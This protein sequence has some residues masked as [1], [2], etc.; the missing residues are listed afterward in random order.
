MSIL[1]FYRVFC[2]Q[3]EI[4]DLYLSLFFTGGLQTNVVH[5]WYLS[6]L[7]Y[8]RSATRCC[9]RFTSIMIL[10]QEVCNQIWSMIYVYSC[11]VTG[12]N[13]PG[14]SQ[15]LWQYLLCY[16][17]YST[18]YGPYMSSLAFVP[19]VQQ[20]VVHALWLPL[21]YYKRYST[22]FSPYMSILAFVPGGVQPGMVHTFWLTLF[23]Y[24]RYSTKFSP[25][26]FILVFVSG[27]VQPGMVH[28][29]WLPLPQVLW[30]SQR[31][32]RG[33]CTAGLVS[34]CTEPSPCTGVWL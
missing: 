6:L 2:N 16:R 13:K 27:G 10:L 31:L 21:F 1:A 12:G 34:I 25:Y 17:R 32:H 33:M 4:Y 3:N 15:L 11:F 26:M 23:R 20:D 28:A 18:R 29:L 8:R 14:L 9:S 7:C 19:G 30:G 24:K 22:K 5:V